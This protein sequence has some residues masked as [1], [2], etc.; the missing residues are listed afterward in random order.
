MKRA[1]TA[2]TAYFLALFALGFIL[3]TV[4]VTIMIP[5]FG[6]L[7]STIAEVPLMI[8]AGYFICRWTIH[9]WQVSRASALRWAMAIWFLLMLIAF[10]TLLGAL[11]FGRSTSEQWATLAT[12]AGIIGMSA[13][14]IAALFPLYIARGEETEKRA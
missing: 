1:L 13:Q 8:T 5:R 11:L 10:E 6:V 7:A 9:N 2:A 4:R 14:V 12:P 3:G